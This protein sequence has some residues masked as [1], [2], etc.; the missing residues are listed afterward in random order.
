VGTGL[1]FYLYGQRMGAPS[2]SLFEVVLDK[3]TG[4]ISAT[5]KNEDPSVT[6]FVVQAFSNALRPL[7]AM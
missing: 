1:K 6:P 5:V 3:S 4:M 2:F 7:P